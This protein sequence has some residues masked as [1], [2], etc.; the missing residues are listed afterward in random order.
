MSEFETKCPKCQ[1]PLS[2]QEEWIGMTVACPTCNHSFTIPRPG[3]Q[4]PI[5]VP[6]PVQPRFAQSQPQGVPAA[7]PVFPQGQPAGGQFNPGGS[8]PYG[9]YPGGQ[10]S[11]PPQASS[12]IMPLLKNYVNFL[13]PDYGCLDGRISRKQFWLV[14]LIL[15]VA[16]SIVVSVIGGIIGGI[17]GAIFALIA[18]N[19]NYAAQYGAEGG[20]IVGG[21]FNMLYL[22]YL[23]PSLISLS[24]R[25]L[26]DSD[27]SGIYALLWFPFF[28]LGLA[29]Q[30]LFVGIVE[31]FSVNFGLLFFP[32]IFILLMCRKGTPGPNRYDE[33]KETKSSN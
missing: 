14:Y 9:S 17:G 11:I 3:V 10:N 16:G 33:K 6:P 32:L 23:Y 15:F 26:H 25:R 18:R 24:V 7:Q 13:S 31:H 8:V 29:N 5:A 28:L 2:V 19:S 22:V 1:S 30:S 12:E 27:L 20:R 4:Q 21:I